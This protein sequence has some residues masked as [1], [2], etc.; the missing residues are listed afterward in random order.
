MEFILFIVAYMVLCFR[1]VTKTVL[2]THRCF[3]C[4]KAASIPHTVLLASRL[5]VSKRLQ[6]DTA[7][8]VDPN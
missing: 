1:F 7:R 3:S 5:G 4:T 6:G 2:I 8:R